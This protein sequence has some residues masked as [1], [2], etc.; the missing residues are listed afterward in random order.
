MM[1][2]HVAD[3]T[4]RI[5]RRG[6]VKPPSLEPDVRAE[7]IQIYRDDILKLQDLIQRDLSKWLSNGQ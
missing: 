7:L 2:Q 3:W 4:G 6:L 1:R 5:Q